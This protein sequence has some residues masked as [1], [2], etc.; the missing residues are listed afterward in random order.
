MKKKM[1]EAGF[2]LRLMAILHYLI[3]RRHK[4]NKNK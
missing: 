4:K 2:E 1:A 3:I